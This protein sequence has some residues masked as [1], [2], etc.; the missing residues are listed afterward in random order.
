MSEALGVMGL[1]MIQ[2]VAI[3]KIKKKKEK[4]RD[5]IGSC[6]GN[7]HRAKVKYTSATTRKEEKDRLYSTDA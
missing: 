2:F 3:F 7:S 5:K 1:I 6:L 4:R